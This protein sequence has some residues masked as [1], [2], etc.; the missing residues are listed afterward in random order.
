MTQ[1]RM[2]LAAPRT[3]EIALNSIRSYPAATLAFTGIVAL[4]GLLAARAFSHPPRW[5]ALARPTRWR[6]L[7][8]RGI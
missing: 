8:H 6:A 2:Q 4:G 5:R 3:A 7:G 1:R